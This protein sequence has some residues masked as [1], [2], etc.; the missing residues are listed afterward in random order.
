MLKTL[1][2][3]VDGRGMALALIAVDR[4][5]NLKA[6]AD[7]LGGKRAKM[8]SVPAAERSTG[9]VKGGISPFATRR[10]LAAVLDVAARE[11]ERVLVNGGRRGLQI[12]LATGD[13]V[14]V[15]EARIAPLARR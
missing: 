4:T 11:H 5:L 9:Y 6:A 2:V 15:L 13:L 8:A 3:E 14:R 12:E 1:V 7:A 10:R